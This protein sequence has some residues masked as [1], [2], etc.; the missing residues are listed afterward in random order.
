MAQ[1]PDFVSGRYA[2]AARKYLKRDQIL[3]EPNH[4]GE[5]IAVTRR[6]QGEVAVFYALRAHGYDVAGNGLDSAVNLLHTKAPIRPSRQ[7]QA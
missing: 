6:N 2:A 1:E 3:L 4:L 5:G 7:T